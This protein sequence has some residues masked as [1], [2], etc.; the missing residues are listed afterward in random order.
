MKSPYISRLLRSKDN[1]VT[2]PRT[3]AG[4]VSGNG[5]VRRLL[6]LWSRCFVRGVCD[7]DFLFLHDWMLL[8]EAD[9]C[10]FFRG[11]FAHC[12]SVLMDLG[13]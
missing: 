2:D 5:A 13:S 10:F 1:P 7:G 9:D 8:M 12:E 6:F 4:E 3:H 11:C